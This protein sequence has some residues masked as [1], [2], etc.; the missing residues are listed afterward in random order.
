[1]ISCRSNSIVI[2]YIDELQ[3]E[4]DDTYRILDGSKFGSFKEKGQVFALISHCEHL[5]TITFNYVDNVP[6]QVQDQVEKS[7]R[8]LMIDKKKVP[9]LF[10]FDS[11]NSPI[12]RGGVNHGLI[13][14]MLINFDTSGEVLVKGAVE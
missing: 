8:Y 12:R 13:G 1:M 10:Y 4:I 11:S 7:N 3:E 2:N 14:G 5:T 9:V 6:V